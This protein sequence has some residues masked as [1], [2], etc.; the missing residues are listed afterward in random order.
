MVNLLVEHNALNEIVNE[1]TSALTVKRLLQWLL[2]WEVNKNE[3]L[4]IEL[5]IKVIFIVKL[6]PLRLTLWRNLALGW[7]ALSAAIG[8]NQGEVAKAILFSNEKG[9][10]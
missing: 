5:Q 10:P 6:L 4:L 1:I 9:A 7:S 3:P 2:A 8:N